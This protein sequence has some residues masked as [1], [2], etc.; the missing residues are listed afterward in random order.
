VRNSNVAETVALIGAS[1]F[2]A[3]QTIVQLLN[4]GN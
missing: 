3:K 2:I 1:G 4:A